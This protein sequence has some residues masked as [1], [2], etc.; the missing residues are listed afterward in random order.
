M[1][2]KRQRGSGPGLPPKRA[3]AGL[4]DEEPP[5]SQFEEDL[6]LL[7]EME[8]ENRLREQEEEALQPALEGAVDGE[9]WSWDPSPLQLPSPLVLPL[10]SGAKQT[11][12]YFE[13]P[14]GLTFDP[15][16]VCLLG[17]QLLF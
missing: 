4:W 9:S 13:S 16:P 3:R 6:A 14:K 5:P 7:E 8:A 10:V 15:F 11:C 17:L 1:D 2:G 12:T